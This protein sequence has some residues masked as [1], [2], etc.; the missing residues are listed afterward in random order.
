M[1]RYIVKSTTVGI[2][3]V[4][5]KDK[6]LIGRNAIVSVSDDHAFFGDAAF[7]GNKFR[8][9]GTVETSGANDAFLIEGP[10]ARIAIAGTGKVTSEHTAIELSG[11]HGD[12]DNNGTI[13]A[14][15]FGI[16]LDAM[17]GLVKNSGTV[18]S[19][20]AGI[21][22]AGKG[23][24]IENYGLIEADRG[25]RQVAAAGDITSTFNSGIVNS[26]IYSFAGAAGN[27]TLLNRGDLNGNVRLYGGDDVFKNIG[28]TVE[29]NIV[30]GLGAD[31]FDIKG[32]IVTGVI[33]GGAG[34]D[35]YIFDSA[36]LRTGE[37]LRGGLDR[38]ISSATY[39]L[40]NNIERLRLSGAES[41][42]GTGNRSANI[43]SGNAGSNVLSGK[44]GNDL[45][46]SFGGSDT[47]D[48]GTG[49][50]RLYGGAGSDTF[51]FASR[52]GHDRIGDFDAGVDKIDLSKF[53]AVADFDDMLD[54][55]VRVSGHNIVIHAGKD[56]LL[57]LHT[58]TSDLHSSDFLF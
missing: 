27:D 54:H 48:G 57:L 10:H 8:I 36:A 7:Y 44:G 49:R 1:T 31:K 19:D 18:T 37:H 50:D 41:I 17:V 38:V 42:D 12:V 23:G 29:G 55:H 58:A 21:Y 30:G 14:V 11:S 35:T 4:G 28:G 56:T 53:A 43:I 34:N 51:V 47:L 45:L 26:T 22:M 13:T 20:Y 6:Y 33:F 15:A 40:G 46:R 16:K 39:T 2:D 9:R 52:Y 25:M 3:L 32:G 5:P 24:E